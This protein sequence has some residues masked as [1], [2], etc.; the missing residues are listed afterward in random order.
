[1]IQIFIRKEK[2]SKNDW[3][4]VYKRILNIVDKFPL[5]LERLESYN[6]FEKGINKTHYNLTIN[7]GTFDEGINFLTDSMSFSAGYHFYVYKNWEKQK[8]MLHGED[9]D[10]NKPIVWS[11][12]EPY[13]D[14]GYPP[15][16]NASGIAESYLDTG[17][18][19]RYAILAIGILLENILPG[20]ALLISLHN[21]HEDIVKVKEWLESIFNETFDIPMYFDKM[22][23]FNTIKDA[24]E[25]KNDLVGRLDKLYRKQTKYNM[26]FA[27]KNIGYKPTLEY[28][29]HVLSKTTFATWGFS[30]ILEAWIAATENLEQALEMIAKSKKIL[31]QDEGKTEEDKKYDKENAKEYDYLY[32][33][34]S[35]LSNYILW[36][37][38]QRE[39]LRQFYTNE[40]ALETGEED[41]FGTMKRMLGY[42]V[43]I[44]PI[45]ANSEKLFEAFMYHLP[46]KGKEFKNLIDKWQEKHKNSYE[47]A[48]KTA[49]QVKKELQEKIEK[50][51]DEEGKQKNE[52]EISESELLKFKR[53]KD[54]FLNNYTK[55]ERFFVSKALV[56][57]PACMDVDAAVEKLQAEMIEFIKN[58]VEE[59][60]YRY[61]KT[62][63]E[64]KGNI[65]YWINEKKHSV[66]PEFEKWLAQENDTNLLSS[67][68]LLVTL[69]FY[70]V[71]QA[72][73][74]SKI[75]EKKEYW[76]NWRKGS[77]YDIEKLF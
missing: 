42:R 10:E 43:D 77:K 8:K 57:N 55:E 48:V 2:I 35:L 69:K 26:I 4:K 62:V 53:K 16:V 64:K 33:L 5:K 58:D 44:C 32:V 13:E 31:L 63:S 75:L 72:F 61:K 21:K 28:Y 19:Y 41:L 15:E 74:R 59:F 49:E 18:V 37:P 36:T 9:Y 6:D 27:L 47:E 38:K 7:E 71:S 46:S 24:Y 66:F 76:K 25:N 54:D 56:R 51:A 73:A 65:R 22:I 30:D 60:K 40:D 29:S 17:A 11:I 70:S 68:W 34:K 12:N 3:E 67:L 14:Y 23:L 20:R 39:F 52:N 1:M 50:K 45:Y